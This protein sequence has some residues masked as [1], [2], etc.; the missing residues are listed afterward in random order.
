M[1][2]INN[3]LIPV[4]ALISGPPEPHPGDLSVADAQP[5]ATDE[6]CEDDD[7]RPTDSSRR[8]FLELMGA[9]LMLAGATGCTRQPTEFILPYVDPPENAVPGRPRYYAT[10]VPAYG[11]AEGVVV[12]NH[13]G[14]PTKVEGNPRHPAS[15]GAAS[16]RSQAS[17]LDLYDPDRAREIT[18][19][20]EPRGW[21]EFLVALRSKLEPLRAGG[22]AG[23]HILSGSVTSPS[24]GAQ[25]AAVQT[26][27]PAAKW[28]QFEPAGAHSA[29]AGAQL[30]FG[31]PMHT[32]YRLESAD[33]VLSLDSDFLASGPDSTRTGPRFRHAPPPRPAFG[34][35]PALRGGKQRD[36]H[37]R[38][39]RPPPS[40]ALLGG[41]IGGARYRGGGR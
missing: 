40:G 15:L 10:A 24:L 12:E 8:R 9:S 23:L 34:H 13:L 16:V 20:T 32:Y 1:P 35:E 5:N 7:D 26:A 27:L 19:L 21:D 37:R 30:A 11:T 28:H 17:V 4:Q 25:L 29:R 41:G 36:Q 18:Y 39:G 6:T 33:V 22:G 14:R 31:G 3:N 38:Q 2:S